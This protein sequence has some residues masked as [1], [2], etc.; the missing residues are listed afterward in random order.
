[1]RS[2]YKILSK[3]G[4]WKTNTTAF[5][6]L[7]LLQKDIMKEIKTF[8]ELINIQSE[9]YATT[10][11]LDLLLHRSSVMLIDGFALV[12]GADCKEDLEIYNLSRETYNKFTEGEK[13]YLE[14]YYDIEK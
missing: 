13:E 4:L 9:H 14:R 3:Q 7:Q 2:S 1:M 5:N 11:A 12:T 6:L 10:C 8:K